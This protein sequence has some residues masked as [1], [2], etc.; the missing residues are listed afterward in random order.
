VKAWLGSQDIWETVEKGFD[1]LIKRVTLILA[2]ME[3]V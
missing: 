1:E 2:Q 3:V